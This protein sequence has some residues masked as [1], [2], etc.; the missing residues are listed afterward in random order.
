[1]SGYFARLTGRSG[2]AGSPIEG[3]AVPRPDPPPRRDVDPFE[4]TDTPGGFDEGTPLEVPAP[5]FHSAPAARIVD[6]RPAAD[7]RPAPA[8]ASKTGSSPAEP[9]N[10]SAA[11][12]HEVA[13][14][15]AA[16]P[17]RSEP[18]PPG[19]A[20]PAGVQPPRRE[21]AAAATRGEDSDA[22]RKLIPPPD[23]TERA[24]SASGSR[25]VRTEP[26]RD[27]PLQPSPPPP[28]VARRDAAEPRL[29][30][31]NMRVEVVPPTQP[32]PARVQVI[33]RPA[34]DSTPR[35]PESNLRFGVGQM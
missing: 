1:M 2:V 12:H 25:I 10:T 9:P 16:A 17:P 19:L 34:A 33:E 3:E 31:G 27:R 23:G 26:Q 29:V 18:A 32:A 7:Q 21:R 30:I 20:R 11:R 5:S 15:I 35:A 4:A 14:H 28:D 22:A 6:S 8:P 13:P 24:V